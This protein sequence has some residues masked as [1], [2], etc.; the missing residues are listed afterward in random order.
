[1]KYLPNLF[2]LS[3][4]AIGLVMAVLYAVELAVSFYW[5]WKDAA[6]SRRTSQRAGHRVERESIPS[7]R[8]PVTR[9]PSLYDQDNDKGNA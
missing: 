5:D 4:I 7:T 2:V 1:M 3:M 6:E 8:S 9:V